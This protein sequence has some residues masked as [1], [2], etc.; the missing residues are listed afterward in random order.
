M[1]VSAA[2]ASMFIHSGSF[3]AFCILY[4]VVVSIFS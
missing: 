2:S 4:D 1:V 3:N